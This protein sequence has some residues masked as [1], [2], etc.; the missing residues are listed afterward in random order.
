VFSKKSL[1]ALASLMA[2]VGTI[3][4]VSFSGGADTSGVGAAGLAEALEGA[5]GGDVI[6]MSEDATLSNDLTIKAGVTLD[7]GGFSLSLSGNMTLVVEGALVSSGDLDIGSM[8]SAIV[9]SGG[10]V[11]IDNEGRTASVT[12]ALTVLEGG[13]L[14]IGSKKS[15]ALDCSGN[16]V[17]TVEGSMSVG[18]G[19]LN[20]TVSINTGVVT[21]KLQISDGS[22]FYVRVALTVGGIPTLLEE[23]NSG[24]AVSGKV[25]LM[26][27]AYVLAYREPGFDENNVRF[28]TASTTFT[29]KGIEYAKEYKDLTGNK[30]IVFPVTSYLKDYEIEKD[31][32]KRDVWTDYDGNVVTEASN[33]QIGST[34]LGGAVSQ[35][36]YNIIF[37]E[38]KSIRWVVNDIVKESSLED[39]RSYNEEVKVGVRSAQGYSDLP[40]IFMNGAPFTPGSTF[41]VMG[42]TSFTTSN[43]RPPPEEDIIVPLVI[44]IAILG[45][46]AA[47]FS[48]A[49]NEKGKRLK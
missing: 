48:V 10:L 42:D 8:S 15:S 37:A 12:G 18:A 27:T 41:K 3:A 5:T 14:R 22:S 7:D 40:T 31:A 38:D 43:N 49:L 4:F 25:Q 17:L 35:I 24:T 34:N 13:T 9:L 28:P 46:I 26:G 33:L 20:S 21:G 36:G 16:G 45:T 19:T 44:I 23:K 39:T 11:A 29:L 32:Q 6:T 30:P 47:A 2:F 1:L